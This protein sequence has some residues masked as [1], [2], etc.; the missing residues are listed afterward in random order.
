M[1]KVSYLGFSS[2]QPSLSFV[3]HCQFRLF[4]QHY[5]LLFFFWS[6]GKSLFQDPSLVLLF[7]YVVSHFYVLSFFKVL[8]MLSQYLKI[9]G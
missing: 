5:I 8:N 6:T 7:S 2:H 3:F 9:G 4:Q 1:V